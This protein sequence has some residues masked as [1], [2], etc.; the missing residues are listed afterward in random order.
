MDPE[1]ERKRLEL[2]ILQIIEDKLKSGEMDADRAK[3][4]ANMLLERLHP[5][6]TLEQLYAIAPTLDDEY[7]ELSRA[8]LPVIREHNEKIKAIVIQ[9]AQTLIESGKL[10]QA[11]ELLK[12]AV[13][14]EG[15]N[16]G[17]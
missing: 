12:Q 4:I 1:E 7:Q 6:L 8:I 9:H 16:N 15:A 10:D 17:R 5:P 13:S 2:D 11:S 14:E 3:S